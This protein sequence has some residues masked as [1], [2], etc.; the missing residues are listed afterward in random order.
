M[1]TKLINVE[2][3]R[4]LEMLVIDNGSAIA[5]CKFLPSLVKQS[6]DFSFKKDTVLP[7]D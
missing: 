7:S 2:V 4:R 5:A 3:R 6:L 1:F